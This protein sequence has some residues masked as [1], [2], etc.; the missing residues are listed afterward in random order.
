LNFLYAGV[1]PSAD[2][3]GGRTSPY[4]PQAATPGAAA[5]DYLEDQDDQGNDHDPPP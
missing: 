2:T 1:R 3:I 4:Y 5:E